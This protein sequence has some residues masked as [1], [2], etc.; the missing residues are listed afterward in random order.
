MSIVREIRED[1]IKC[2]KYNYALDSEIQNY[3]QYDSLIS[4]SEDGTELIITNKKPVEN[5]DYILDADPNIIKEQ[6][7]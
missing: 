3:L 7:N 4:V 5:P 1:P 6:Q 2:V